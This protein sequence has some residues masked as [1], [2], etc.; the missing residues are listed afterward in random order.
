NRHSMRAQI[1]HDHVEHH[2]R[3]PMPEVAVAVGR[4]AADVHPDLARYQRAQR[5]LTVG[6]T[7]VDLQHARRPPRASA[8]NLIEKAAPW[9]THLP[10]RRETAKPSRFPEQDRALP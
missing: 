9:H 6:P 7:V 10:W 5:F 2:H 1:A 8:G 4:H 3:P